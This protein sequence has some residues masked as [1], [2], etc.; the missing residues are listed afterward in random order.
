MY[1]NI[2]TQPSH[3]VSYV[4]TVLVVFAVVAGCSHK[5]QAPQVAA[6][7]TILVARG[8]IAGATSNDDWYSAQQA[9]Q[10]DTLFGQKCAV[11]HGAKLQGAPV[12]HSEAGSSSL[13]TQVNQ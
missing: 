10:G 3:W 2:S 1:R 13:D 8:S 7:S 11:C 5:A 6:S 9:S 4:A 12:L